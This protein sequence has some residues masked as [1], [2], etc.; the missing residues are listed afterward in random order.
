MVEIFN[1]LIPI[2]GCNPFR[3]D[4]RFITCV[5]GIELLT[6]VF[7]F[8]S[9]DACSP[10]MDEIPFTDPLNVALLQITFPEP[11]TEKLLLIFFRI[12]ENIGALILSLDASC[13]NNAA[14]EFCSEVDRLFNA[15]AKLW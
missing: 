4:W 11:S 3:I 6:N 15:D 1:P 13:V 12:P 14:V 10:E 7:C 5:I 9:I 8:K 2:V